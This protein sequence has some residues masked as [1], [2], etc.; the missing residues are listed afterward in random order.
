M[1]E[2]QH[3]YIGRWYDMVQASVDECTPPLAAIQ[4]F[5][6]EASP[7]VPEGDAT[8]MP[9]ADLDRGLRDFQSWAHATLVA[10]PLSR[11][12][13]IVFG[14][15]HP[16]DS[17]PDLGCDIDVEGCRYRDPNE[18]HPDEPRLLSGQ[19]KSVWL[20]DWYRELT[21]STQS[22]SSRLQ[23]LATVMLPLV[24][25]ASSITAVWHQ[26]LEDEILADL[27]DTDVYA[28]WSGGSLIRVIG[29]IT[30]PT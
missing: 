12:G 4:R 27:R 19:M 26:L 9:L 29:G 20:R 5:L 17:G 25:L 8:G 10:E 7:D 18:W 11:L 21:R 30:R 3:N 28:I 23:C 22:G 24:F 2:T 6:L 13:H 15:Y 1:S 16:G 14:L